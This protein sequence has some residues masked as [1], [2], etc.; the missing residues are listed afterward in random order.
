MKILASK[1][2]GHYEGTAIVELDH[3]DLQVFVRLIGQHKSNF[4][5]LIAFD[6]SSLKKAA[7]DAVRDREVLRDIR[8]HHSS[9]CNLISPPAPKS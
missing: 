3:H 8:A 4:S 9:L 1:H 5:D 6:Y 7:Q 2:N